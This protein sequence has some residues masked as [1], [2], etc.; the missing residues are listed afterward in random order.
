MCKLNSVG[1]SRQTQ[2][3]THGDNM[4]EQNDIIFIYNT[5]TD[6]RNILKVSQLLNI[7]FPS[8][9]IFSEQEKERMKLIS[10]KYF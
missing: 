5:S 2:Y 3:L 8:T 1:M 7:P 9:L 4:R 6:C 10:L